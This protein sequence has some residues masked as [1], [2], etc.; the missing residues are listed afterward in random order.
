[1]AISFNMQIAPMYIKK[2]YCAR[3]LSL[4]VFFKQPNHFFH[5][6]MRLK[7]LFC[8]ILLAPGWLCAQDTFLRRQNHAMPI[9]ENSS[10]F[11]S[12]FGSSIAVDGDY[13][14]VGAPTHPGDIFPQVGRVFVYRRSG[15]QWAHVATLKPQE[16]SASL[17]FGTSV[18]ISGNIIVVGA[19]NAFNPLTENNSGGAYFFR[20]G[21]TGWPATESF[22]FLPSDGSAHTQFA[23]N[24]VIG[25]VN[26]VVAVFASAHMAVANIDAETTLADQ[27]KVYEFR[28]P[29]PNAKTPAFVTEH[30]IWQSTPFRNG[31]TKGAL[32]GRHIAINGNILA[33]GATTEAVP[34][35]NGP[36]RSGAVYLYDITNP[37]QEPFMLNSPTNDPSAQFGFRIALESNRM[38]VSSIGEQNNA[39]A[40]YYYTREED[41]PWQLVTRFTAD[42]Q[43]E[44][45]NFGN[46]LM[47]TPRRAVISAP[48]MDHDFEGEF[49]Q[50]AG[51]TYV[52]DLERSNFT[53]QTTPGE[54]D[55]LLFDNFA[56]PN[57]NKSSIFGINGAYHPASSSLLIASRMGGDNNNGGLHVFQPAFPPTFNG[58]GESFQNLSLIPDAPFSLSI[59]E[60]TF[61]ITNGNQLHY[62]VSMSKEGAEGEINWLRFSSENLLFS[63]TPGIADRGNYTVQVV[64]QTDQVGPTTTGTFSLSVTNRAPVRNAAITDQEVEAGK[65]LTFSMDIFSDADEDPLTYTFMVVDLGDNEDGETG[66]LMLKSEGTHGLPSWLIFDAEN[67]TLSG[68]PTLD[69]LGTSRLRILASDGNGGQASFSFEIRVILPNNAPIVNRTISTQAAFI[70]QFFTFTFDEKT[71]RRLRSPSA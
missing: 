60:N 8:F 18:A 10:I 52:F 39:G 43:Q 12:R 46:F 48:R 49:V 53:A 16:E 57:V 3:L 35:D 30:H 47:F 27:G 64:T 28:L 5:L 1:M 45:S 54:A 23:A 40:A 56:W 20:E 55:Q 6:F 19:P 11:M 24:L 15:F 7:I 22:R 29:N 51:I 37:E 34:E 4:Q 59:P 14:V 21:V 26:G 13:A 32:F 70:G 31:N 25:N 61:A 9:V 38:L 50:T 69:H 63:G 71:A 2:A 41:G 42:R 67:L 44:N 65:P 17:N 62:T 36:I 33:V 66:R 68:T 58:F